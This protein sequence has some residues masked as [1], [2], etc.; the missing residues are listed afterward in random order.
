MTRYLLAIVIVKRFKK[1][2]VLNLFFIVVTTLASFSNFFHFFFLIFLFY[3]RRRR[4]I[5]HHFVVKFNLDF[6]SFDFEN[7]QQLLIFSF[8]KTKLIF[9]YFRFLFRLSQEI[10]KTSHF[11]VCDIYSM[12]N[13]VIDDVNHVT[14]LMSLLHLLSHANNT[15]I[16]FINNNE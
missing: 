3:R 7:I 14:S 6:N 9:R 12:M 5:F 10:S 2:V 1:N 4:A 8:K 16:E 11:R 15:T 13:Y